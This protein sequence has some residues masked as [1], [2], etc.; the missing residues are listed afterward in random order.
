MVAASVLHVAMLI[1][2]AFCWRRAYA[3]YGGDVGAADACVRYGVGTFVNAVAP[4]RLGG[5]VRIGLFGGSLSGAEAARR[6][7]AA[8]GVIGLVRLASVATLAAGAAAVGLAPRWLV[9]APLAVATGWIGAR[10]ALFKHDRPRA[11]CV[12]AAGAWAGLAALCRCAS[13][14]AAAAAVGVPSPIA[15][16]LV[17]LVGLE[18]SSLLPL[19]PGLAGL[20]GAA[21]AVALAAAGVPSTTAVGAG[22]AFHVAESVAGLTVGLLATTAFLFRRAPPAPASHPAT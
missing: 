4:A 13:I 21:V 7:A 15:A 11:R 12:A 1:A 19:A 16:G 18:L 6:S 3:G 5:A 14:A 10:R 9:A 2:S 17:G 8:L 20:G 22:I